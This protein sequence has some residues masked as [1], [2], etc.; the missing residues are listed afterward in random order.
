MP[1]AATAGYT[2]ASASRVDTWLSDSSA[3]AWCYVDDLPMK[4]STAHAIANGGE[5]PGE[6]STCSSI[7]WIQSESPF[8]GLR[9]C[10][11]QGGFRH[12]CPP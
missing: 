11:G 6:D 2:S 3:K 8:S 5:A 1:R 12:R 9:A 10:I 4:Q 7:S